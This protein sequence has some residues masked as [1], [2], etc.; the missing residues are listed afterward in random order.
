LCSR[1]TRVAIRLSHTGTGIQSRKPDLRSQSRALP[2]PLSGEPGTTWTGAG[3]RLAT[4]SVKNYQPLPGCRWMELVSGDV[5]QFVTPT[6]CRA[7]FLRP[8]SF[9]CCRLAEDSQTLDPR[10]NNPGARVLATTQST[11]L[12]IGY[13]E[14]FGVRR[15][16]R[17][18][19]NS[20]TL[21][22]VRVSRC[23]LQGSIQTATVDK[24]Q[25]M[26][27]LYVVRNRRRSSGAVAFKTTIPHSL[28]TPKATRQGDHGDTA[29][30]IL[31]SVCV[32][33]AAAT[34]DEEPD[35]QNNGSSTIYHSS[36]P[37]AGFSYPSASTRVGARFSRRA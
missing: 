28:A 17:S 29:Q 19:R 30:Y 4:T 25:V 26:E 16:P 27:E 5:T 21:G 36:R 18:S 35:Q 22:A 8:K 34:T 20:S 1:T 6:C 2:R 24:M 15:S 37:R 12:R 3:H 33:S 11:N 14:A 31:D 13:V 10:S 23:L 32:S 7:N 9:L